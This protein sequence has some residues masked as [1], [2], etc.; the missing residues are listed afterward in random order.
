MNNIELLKEYFER[1]W[2]IMRSITGEGVRQTHKII[3]ELIPL[4]Q[5][6]LPTG[7]KVFDWTIPK[8]WVVRDAYL[9]DPDGKKI[10]N[11]KNNNLHLL[12][13]SIPFKGKVSREQLEGH[14]YSIPELPDAIPYR[15]SYY[16]PRWGFCMSE[17]QRRQLK[18]GIYGVFIDTDLIEGSLTISEA[19]L[20]G[21]TKQEVLISTYTCHPSLANN[22]L[23]GPLV[24]SF[25][26]KKLSQQKN[27]RLTYRFVFLPETI[28]SIAY[29]S[30][31]GNYLKKHLIAGYVLTC[32]GTKAPFIYKRSRRGNSMA[33][34]AAEYVLEKIF[35]NPKLF[36]S[37]DH[38]IKTNSRDLKI[39]NF[40]PHGGS[41]ERQYCSPGF[42]LPVGSISR[43]MY[44]TYK[45]YHTSLD[46]QHFISFEAMQEALEICYEICMTLEQNLIYK[47][48]IM[49]CEPQLGAYGL[50]PSL[51]AAK[52]TDKSID[53]IMWL[54]NLS[55]GSQDL[56]SIAKK[57]GIDI[58]I[59][60]SEAQKCLAKGLIKL[61]KKSKAQRDKNK[62]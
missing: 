16:S 53:A 32:I 36:N 52:S 1:L 17:N 6:E 40:F 45:E 24:A 41:D 46:N 54:L 4:K 11:I 55:D 8:E 47:N 18:R 3:S 10:I 29:L 5:I 58:N 7:M 60:Y 14:I 56:I 26:Y 50:Y 43:S 27:R 19:V 44:G 37:F 34:Q 49:F 59:I 23:S 20:P 51:G 13:Y 28:G 12:N 9:I 61:E 48:R 31:Y 33:D 39:I 62:C 30:I 38:I 2:P 57:S 25:L 22:E 42:D 21:K 35:D 15:T